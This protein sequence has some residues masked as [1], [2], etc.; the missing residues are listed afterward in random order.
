MKS[1]KISIFA[2]LLILISYQTIAQEIKTKGVRNNSLDV[3]SNNYYQTALKFSLSNFLLN[4]E[5]TPEGLFYNIEANGFTKS[6]SIGKAQLPTKNCMLEIPYGADLEVQINHSQFEDFDLNTMGYTHKIMPSQPSYSKSSEPSDITFM[7]DENYYQTDFFDQSPLIKT[8]V[9]GIMRGVRIGMVSISPFSYNP[10]KNILRVYKNIEFVIKYKNPEIVKTVE[11]KEK[12]Y[13]PLFEQAHNQLINYQPPATKDFLS[14]YPIKYVIVSD[15]AFQSVLQP[16]I[17]WKVRKGFTVVEAYTNNPLVGT[18]TTSIKS[19]L[20]GLYNS[21]SSG[22]PAPSYVLFV[23]DIAQIPTFTGTTGSHVTD[24]YY[25]EYDGGGDYLPEIYYGRFSANNLT[26]LQPQ[27][28]K[29]LLYEQYTMFH[30]NFLDTAVLVAGDDSN[31]APVYANGQINYATNNYVN[32]SNSLYSYTYLYPASASAGAQMRAD[33]YKGVGFAN[34]TAH[35]N[36]NG[37]GG[38]TFT[39]SNVPSMAEGKFSFIV[40]NCCLPNKFNEPECFGEALLRASNKGAIGHVGASNNTYWDEDYYFAVGYTSNIVSN[41]TYQGTGLGAYDRLFH[42]HGEPESEWFITNGQVLNAGCLSVQASNSSRKTYVWEEYHLMGDP[43]VMTYLHKPLP[44]TAIYTNPILAG[45]GTLTINTDPYAYAA[46]SHNGILLNAAKADSNGVVTLNF[47]PFLLPD[48]ADIVVTKQNKQPFI[49]Q[50]FITA[51]QFQ[52]DASIVQIIEPLDNY[53]CLGISV[54][55][56]VLIR[57]FGLTALTS[58]EIKYQINNGTLISHN[59]TGNLNTFEQDTITLQSLILASGSQIIRVF[60]NS[61]NNVNDENNVNDTLIKTITTQNLPVQAVFV[62][63]DSVFCNAPVTVEFINQSMNATSYQW[64]F[65]DGFTSSDSNPSHTYQNIGT[66]NVTL[67]ADAGIC[68]T[69]TYNLP[70][71]IS[72]GLSAPNV[73]NAQSCGAGSFT[74]T[75]SGYGI[76]NWYAS[77]NDTVPIY[78]GTNYSIPYLDTTTSFYVQGAIEQQSQ[79]A[80][81]YDN[82]G[83]GGNFNNASNWHYQIFNTYTPFKL[84]SV[85]VYASGG[86]QRDILLRDAAGNTLDSLNIFIPDGESRVTL[87][88]DIP[89]GSNYQLV[90]AGAVD[91]YRNNNNSATYPYELPGVLSIT[92]S[93]ASLPPYNV[94]GNYYYFYDWEVKK[95]DCLSVFETVTAYVLDM[96]QSDFSYNVSGY[97]VS[98]TN[99]SSYAMS[100]L[101]D[102]GDG[103]TSTLTNPMHT[104]ITPGQYTVK[105]NV[106]NICGEDSTE[107]YIT[108]QGMA[109][110]VDFSASET[111]ITAGDSIQFNDLSLFQPDTWSWIFE[112]GSP[113]SS[114]L[115]NPVITYNTAGTYYVTLVAG[116]T[117]GNGYEH[118]ALYIQV[119]PNS[120]NQLNNNIP[121]IVLYPN[122]LSNSNLFIQFE[123]NKS[124]VHVNICN[125]LGE[126]I[127]S[128]YF[129][130][131]TS[132]IQ[133]NTLNLSSGMY[134]LHFSDN[135]DSQTIKFF[136]K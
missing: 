39:N 88:M 10:A 50:L 49:G 85:K 46:I 3:V 100:N 63:S 17:A 6:Y 119:D 61:P 107:T 130:K 52:N 22:N 74:L 76:I 33:I 102:F 1:Q 24:L 26:E 32:S 80:G 109:P 57:N 123:G 136:V 127:F 92:E 66:Y 73:V 31:Y 134:V 18:T 133:L 40:S 48:T 11:M 5:N 103:N 37:W 126:I 83:S 84:I 113:S 35:C 108:L 64:N 55:P 131:P 77:P 72:V 44:L 41:P 9:C 79:S 56:K 120:I 115:Q 62:T 45:E 129:E 70:Y 101:W 43:S 4:Q 114:N 94:N 128:N 25:A 125:V 30:K 91:L 132:P 28:D 82:S 20:Q 7:Y 96:P 116:N 23:G 105:L 58:L 12:Y 15:P 87:N 117:Y 104:Y 112:G 99:L 93:S 13:S 21:A 81:K 53:P 19:Y 38:P 29:T 27:I 122:P 51:P 8:E 65:G 67:V 111:L 36:Y 97:T 34:Y 68:G 71:A 89:V 135:T 78:S 54:S 90:G 98:F 124:N 75:A 16:F 14:T 59:W 95:E 106:V 121:P 110:D 60:V 42:T 118:K 2:V 47:T 69:S 86:G